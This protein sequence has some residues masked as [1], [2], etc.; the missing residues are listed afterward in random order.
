MLETP[1]ALS[2]HEVKNEEMF[3]M[4]NQQE[5]L[6]AWLAGILDGEGSLMIHVNQYK[7]PSRGKPRPQ[8]IPR[9]QIGSTSPEIIEKCR[10]AINQYTGCLVKDRV[11]P[12][13]KIFQTVH[14]V[15]T[16]RA[17]AL[18]PHVM[19]YLT[20]KLSKAKAIME[21]IHS[22]QSKNRNTTYTKYEWALVAATHN[23]SSE[24]TC[25]APV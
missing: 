19:E 23:G 22:R 7:R 2:T 10:K 25:E 24:T 14:V 3:T 17:Q 18:L 12:S 8:L 21:F 4:D 20:L 9:I 16:K 15:G 13:G 6:N 11:L 5:T 1:K